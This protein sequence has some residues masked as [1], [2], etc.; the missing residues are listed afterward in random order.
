MKCMYFKQDELF[1]FQIL[2]QSLHWLNSWESAYIRNE[3]SK[4]EMLSMD[5][6]NSL[7]LSLQSTIDMC[8]YLTENFSFQYLLS[9]KVNQDN[10][11]VP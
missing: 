7:R 2:H 5:T 8:T 10:L 1:M 6:I 9:G 11:E 4:D 3:I